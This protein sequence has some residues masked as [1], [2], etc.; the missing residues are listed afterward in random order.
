MTQGDDITTPPREAMT[1]VG[2]NHLVQL[3]S[4]Y[5]VRGSRSTGASTMA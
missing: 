5:K 3:T 2:I 4:F 1:P